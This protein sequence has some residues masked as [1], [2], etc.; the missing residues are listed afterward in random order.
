MRKTVLLYGIPLAILIILLRLLEHRVFIRDLSLE[1]Y[2]GIIAILFTAIGVWAGRKLI[3]PK[4]PQIQI[5]HQ[6][7]TA[8]FER[9][10]DALKETGVSQ[11]ELDVLEC[12][13][14]GLSN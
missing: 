1:F 6:P 14:K 8:K 9:N 5:I 10:E 3:T 12:I 7:L 13:S 4:A 11:R 2:V